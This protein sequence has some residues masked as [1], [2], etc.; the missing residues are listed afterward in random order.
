VSK[1]EIKKSFYKL[2]PGL[3]R[4]ILTDLMSELPNEITKEQFL[5]FFGEG[6]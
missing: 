6:N 5:L 3:P 1:D 2:L 4:D